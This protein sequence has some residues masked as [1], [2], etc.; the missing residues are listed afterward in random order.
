MVQEFDMSDLQFEHVF[1]L[2]DKDNSG[3][4]DPIEMIDLLKAY[5]TWLYEKQYVSA[6]EDL[7]AEYKPPEYE[8]NDESASS[9]TTSQTTKLWRKAMRIIASP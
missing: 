8:D 5:E 1:K 2:I 4:L 6:M 9:Q 7:Y 3:F